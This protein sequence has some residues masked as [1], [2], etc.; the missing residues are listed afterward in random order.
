MWQETKLGPITRCTAKIGIFT[1]QLELIEPGAR[2]DYFYPAE[3]QL[4]IAFGNWTF[5]HFVPF[6]M[7][8]PHP[9]DAEECKRLAIEAV[10]VTLQNAIDEIRTEN[11]KLLTK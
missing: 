2:G 10:E 7:R 4:L 3:C 11:N 9:A 5:K 6:P 8:F 1:L